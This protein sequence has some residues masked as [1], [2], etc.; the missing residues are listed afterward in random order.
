MGSPQASTAIWILVVF[1]ATDFPMAVSSPWAAPL[2]CLDDTPVN[3][4]PF[5]IWLYYKRIENGHQFF[6][7]APVIEPLVDGIPVPKNFG[8]IPPRTSNPQP[9]KNS[10]D[11]LSELWLGVNT[12]F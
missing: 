2:L 6:L 1:P 3:E 9:I 11:G 4:F 10:F 7:S 5:Q 8:Q 12:Q